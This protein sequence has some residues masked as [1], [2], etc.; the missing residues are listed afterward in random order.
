MDIME[1]LL[2]FL[3]NKKALEFNFVWMFAL[4]IGALILFL[5]IFSAGKFIKSESY[6]AET[7]T[8][9]QIV[10]IFE[11]AETGIAEGVRME[12]LS[13]KDETK[14]I[15][16]CSDYETFGNQKI[17]ISSKI[18]GKWQ[19]TGARIET[20][21]KYIFSDDVEQGK[22]FYYF[23]KTFSMPFKV[24]ELIF[25]S[26][27]KYCFVNAPKEIYDEASF[28]MGNL[29]NCSDDTIKVC[30]NR[31]CEITVTGLCLRGCDSEYDYGTV[32]KDGKTM[33]YVDGLMYGA[34]FASYD[35][36]ECNVKRLGKRLGYQAELISKQASFISGKCETNLLDLSGIA[37]S[38]KKIKNS[39]D[40]L[41][42]KDSADNADRANMAGECKL[43]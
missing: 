5:A 32:S 4:A 19:E 30:F 27:K 34:I 41:L 20:S 24:A 18:L 33:T 25:L 22:K 38:G 7:L 15:D 23:S 13:L 43:W 42:I 6:E 21:N 39:Q 31:P 2:N 26:G 8:A 35:I 29:V 40:L 14:I 17:G 12:A 11:T 3:K 9:K 28:L 36:Y 10:N 16:Y 37:V 1:N